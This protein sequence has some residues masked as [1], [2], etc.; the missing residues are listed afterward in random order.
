MRLFGAVFLGVFSCV[1]KKVSNLK[2][3]GKEDQGEGWA[4]GLCC[5]LWCQLQRAK[6]QSKKRAEKTH[7]KRIFLGSRGKCQE[8]SQRTT[9]KGSN[10][11]FQAFWA[12]FG[13]FSS[14][15]FLMSAKLHPERKFPELS[16]FCP[17]FDPKFP[18]KL[19]EKIHKS[20]LE[21]RQ[22]NFFTPLQVIYCLSLSFLVLA[23]LLFDL[24]KGSDET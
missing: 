2:Q 10:S 24:C 23:G 22:S 17:E 7:P 13:C 15:F 1:P 11:C 12:L 9:R 19:E 8:S 21:R 6:G 3:Q 16:N 20:F 18:G 5:N 14:I 4:G